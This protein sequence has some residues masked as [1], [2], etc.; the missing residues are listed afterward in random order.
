[1]TETRLYQELHER[2]VHNLK[3]KALDPFLENENFRRAIK[4]VDT[5]GVQDLRQ[6][7]SQ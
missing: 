6:E 1:M 4:D 5:S 3:E 2:Y 7:D